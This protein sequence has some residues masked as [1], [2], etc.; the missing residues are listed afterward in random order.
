MEK[1]SK[2]DCEKLKV[3]GAPGQFGECPL[4]N[5]GVYGGIFIKSCDNPD[6]K[7]YDIF[8]MQRCHICGTVRRECCC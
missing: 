8:S 5:D 4:C 6:C 7:A 2:E 1:L 3:L